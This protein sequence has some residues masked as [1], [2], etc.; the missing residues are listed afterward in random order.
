MKHILAIDLG[1]ASISA[2]VAVQYGKSDAKTAAAP[3]EVLK[4]LRY[5]INLLSYQLSGEGSKVPYILKDG[6]L[7]M[8]KEANGVSRHVDVILIALSDPF[9]VD[10]KVKKILARPQHALLISRAEV[11]ALVKSLEDEVET[12]PLVIAGSGTVNAKVSGYEVADPVGYTGKSLEV[13]AVFTLISSTLKNYMAEAKE[14]FFPGSEVRYYSDARV[15]WQALRATENLFDPVLTVDI[16]GEVTGVFWADKHTI[17]HAGASAF[18]IRTLA[19]R[20][21]A[22]FK[23]DLAEAE[24]LLKKYT[25]G[26]LD[27][28]LKAK[29]DRALS[30]ALADW[31]LSFKTAGQTLPAG[32]LPQKAVLTGGGADFAPFAAFLK[33]NFRSEHGIDLSIQTLLAEAFSDFLDPPNIFSGGGDV[34]LT[35]LLI[36]EL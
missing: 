23:T 10:K 27:E 11:G 31:W 24:A 20:V 25:A 15:L 5:P 29:L 9:F 18:G 8:F 17:E 7:K 3:C 2:A 22:S 14:K 1:T 26:T 28:A 12:G 32:L 30:S 6:F 33:D 35:S 4:V 36:F 13:E 21:G 34:I 16:G 19:R